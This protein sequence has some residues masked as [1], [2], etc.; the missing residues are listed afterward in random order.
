MNPIDTRPQ[1]IAEIT[2][3]V[4]V[5]AGLVSEHLTRNACE[6]DAP[7]LRDRELAGLM[8]ATRHLSIRAH[9]LAEALDAAERADSDELPPSARRHLMAAFDALRLEQGQGGES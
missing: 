8:D 3:S 9:E 7:F 5:I 2:H 1:D 4:G 6:G